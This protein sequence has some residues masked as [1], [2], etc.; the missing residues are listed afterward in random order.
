MHK[1]LLIG[2]VITFGIHLVKGKVSKLKDVA[3]NF[4][5]RITNVRI[6]NFD[7]S[8]LQFS[9]DVII[10]NNTDVGLT[11]EDQNYLKIKRIKVF[12]QDGKLLADAQT[13]I[14]GIKIIPEGE[15]IIQGVVLETHLLDAISEYLTNQFTGDY[16]I[17][18]TLEALGKEWVVDN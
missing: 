7:D 2:S 8:K 12:R 4:T 15:T 17:Q 6:L 10:E 11:I 18:T 14:S 16:T 3:K 13:N 5:T 9:V 1:L